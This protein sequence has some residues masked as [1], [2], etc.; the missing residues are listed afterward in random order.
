MSGHYD[1]RRIL[2]L[3]A[4]ELATAIAQHEPQY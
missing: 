1:F 2:I 4:I 3:S